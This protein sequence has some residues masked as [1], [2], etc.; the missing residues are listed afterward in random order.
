MKRGLILIVA[1]LV[2]LAPEASSRMTWEGQ[3]RICRHLLEEVGRLDPE[4]V[5]AKRLAGKA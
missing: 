1:L 5:K 2:L 4:L 3:K